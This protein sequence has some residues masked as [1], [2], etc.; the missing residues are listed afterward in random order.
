MMQ[1]RRYQNAWF[2]VLFFAQNMTLFGLTT[3]TTKTMNAINAISKQ[4]FPTTLILPFD[5]FYPFGVSTYL[6]NT[7]P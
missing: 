4:I 2:L 5:I 7:L 3:P 6:F 1:T